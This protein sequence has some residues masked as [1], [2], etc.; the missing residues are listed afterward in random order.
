MAL[1]TAAPLTWSKICAEFDV[2]VSTPGSQM[3]KGGTHVPNT[4][5]NANVPAA[6]PINGLSFLGAAKATALVFNQP[7]SLDVAYYCNSFN[8][9]CPLDLTLSVSVDLTSYISG[10]DGT[11]TV[12]LIHTGRTAMP[13]GVSGKVIRVDKLT[14]RNEIYTGD[15]TVR[16][17]SAG[18]TVDRAII[19]QTQYTWENVDPTL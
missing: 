5:T 13:V 2:P 19:A 6:L 17:T 11:Y 1:P 4:T 10:G 3:L 15:Y 14:G 12:Q 16:V 7:P 8:S 18:M 9:T